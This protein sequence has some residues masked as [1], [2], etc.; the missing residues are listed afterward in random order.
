M[1]TFQYETGEI[2]E[3]TDL[4]IIKV[5]KLDK[6]YNELSNETNDNKS[7]NCEIENS[8]KE[9]KKNQKEQNE[10]KS[11]SKGVKDGEVQE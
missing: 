5:L 11:K 6:R 10:L 3:V 1:A 9:N 4:A 7:N 8:K 2:I